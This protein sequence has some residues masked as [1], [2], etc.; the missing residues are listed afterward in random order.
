[1]LPMNLSGL[2]S[3]V[4]AL[5]LVFSSSQGSA[6]EFPAD[7]GD[8]GMRDT[9]LNFDSCGGWGDAGGFG[10]GDNSSG[11]GG[12]TGGYEGPVGIDSGTGES[13]FSGHNWY[14]D[15]KAPPQ[16]PPYLYK[17][18]IL[19][20]P[21]TEIEQVK[22]YAL[23]R[24]YPND[25]LD[26]ERSKAYNE[27][28]AWVIVERKR[29]KAEED[30]NVYKAENDKRITDNIE[31][32]KRQAEES[33]LANEKLEAEMAPQRLQRAQDDQRRWDNW[34]N[35]LAEKETSRLAQQEIDIARFAEIDRQRVAGWTIQ[36]EERLAKEKDLHDQK[37]AANAV[38][39]KSRYAEE[40]PL[41]GINTSESLGKTVVAGLCFTGE[42]L[43]NVT[44][45]KSAAISSIKKGDVVES[46]NF[47][48]DFACEP[49]TVTNIIKNTTN[50]L[51]N[52]KVSGRILRVTDNHPFYVIAVGAWVEARFLK[53][54]D[55]LR[56]LSG[57]GIV[58][59]NIGHEFGNFD[60]YNLEVETNHNY[61]AEGILAHNCTLGGVAAETVGMASLTT[62]I[63]GAVVTEYM[64]SKVKDFTARVRERDTPNVVKNEST[65]NPTTDGEGQTAEQFEETLPGLPPGE[66][67]AKVREKASNV[68]NE[69]KWTRN[70]KLSTMNDR[71]VYTDKNGDHYSV[72]TQHGRLEKFDRRGR[73]QGELDMNLKPRK[74]ADNS[75]RHDIEV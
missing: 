60:V 73:H 1:K 38:A 32:S 7:C 54:G 2:N 44:S 5:A 58:I 70:N 8:G 26:K 71:P 59:D 37:E 63:A 47:E 42:T 23:N 50:H 72:D 4:L 65:K 16:G 49:Q 14:T 48:S 74:P 68:A 53:V 34:L 69:Q 56:T 20:K 31:L 30:A 52:I 55:S 25:R 61:F 39:F 64:V 19:T 67:V 36:Q 22:Y 18:L 43:I 12:G 51:L 28:N 6:M 33:R 24:I 66:R 57:D 29:V 13:V 3:A 35:E 40:K 21:R 46:C 45:Y 15:P 62:L 75:G 41:S 17:Y 11:F 27:Y 9:Y 10:G